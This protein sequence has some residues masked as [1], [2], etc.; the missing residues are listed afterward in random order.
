MGGFIG[1]GDAG[2]LGGFTIKAPTVTDAGH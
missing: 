1:G 2:K